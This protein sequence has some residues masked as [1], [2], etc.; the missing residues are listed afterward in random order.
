MNIFKKLFGKK[1]KKK[2]VLGLALGS[3]GAKG[4]ATLGA[5]FAFSESNID[6]DVY[7][8]T[9]IGSIIGAFLA[10]GYS[11]ADILALWRGTD[12]K[13]IKSTVPINMD[14][15]GLFRIIDNTIGSLTIEELKKPFRAVATDLVTGEEKVFS[16]GNVAKVLCASSAIPPYFKPVEIDGRKYIDGAFV[17]SVPADVVKG[18][19][20]DIVIGIDLSTKN[21][22]ASLISKILPSFK[23][24]VE[25]PWE[26]GYKNSD[27]MLH[28]DLNDY[29]S[30]DY[31][32]FAE[33]FDIGYDCAIKEMPRIK[34]VI[35]NFNNKK[36]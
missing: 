22:Q 11:C 33:M 8:G 35:A 2:P 12:T 32:A 17:N 30:T 23:G 3:G 20:A 9:S 6:F 10:D 28:P 29:K 27:I 13:S 14:T 4:F 24:G 19:G 18:L 21:S 34:E 15:Q 25:C 31:A 7:A 5:L 36:R 26:K 1:E 16:L